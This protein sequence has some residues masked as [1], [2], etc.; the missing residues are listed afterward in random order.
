ME[1]NGGRR[2]EAEKNERLSQR[3]QKIAEFWDQFNLVCDEFSSEPIKYSN[4]AVDASNVERR[5]QE[6]TRNQTPQDDP[7]FIKIRL[8]LLR[9]Q[10]A[11]LEYEIED[12]DE[13]FWEE[14]TTKTAAA[15][16]SWLR[17][18]TT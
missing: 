9:D 10:I 7:E 3:K 18:I 16:D 5:L 8:T 14:W 17:E 2:L 1:T 13:D 4:P 11:D 6:L 12:C 15:L